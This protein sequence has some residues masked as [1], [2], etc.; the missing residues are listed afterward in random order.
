M[1]QDYPFLRAC[2]RQPVERVPLWLMRQAG[3]Y[4][5]EYRALRQQHSI[6]ELCRTPELAAQV[7]MQPI[8]RYDLDAA[9]I[10]ADILLPLEGLGVGFQFT[11]GEGP[12]IDRPIR[13][14]EDADAVKPFDPTVGLG[15]VLEAIK[16]VRREL[17]GRVP[18]IGFAGAPFTLASYGLRRSGF[19]CEKHIT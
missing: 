3:R 17:E 4:M 14:P 16:I 13:T 12:V 18:L 9:I 10:F 1:T 15:Y 5:P 11:A 6:L 7:T 8:N 19:I 2:R